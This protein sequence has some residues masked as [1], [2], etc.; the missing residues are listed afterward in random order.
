[1]AKHEAQQKL[2]IYIEEYTGRL[3]HHGKSI[4]SFAELW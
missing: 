4:E 1:M 2:A 3:I